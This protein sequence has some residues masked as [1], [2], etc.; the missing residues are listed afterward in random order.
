MKR[1]SVNEQDFL[2]F[3]NQGLNDKEI[4][5]N[6]NISSQTVLKFRKKLN[7]PSK[8]KRKSAGT[9]EIS[10]EQMEL[11]KGTLLG[12]SSLQLV[13]N[14]KTPIFTLYHGPNQRSYA[15]HIAEKLNS[16]GAK[17][18]EYCRLD[19]RTLKEQVSC[20]VI[21]PANASFLELYDNLYKHKKKI[22]TKEFLEGF[23][24]RSLAYLIMDDGYFSKNTIHICTDSFDDDSLNNMIEYFKK[25]F[26]LNFTKEKKTEKHYRLRLK[27]ADFKLF[28]YLVKPY[29]LK[30]LQYKLGD[31]T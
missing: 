23:T 18:K 20:C 10:K 26:D 14:A 16:I 9:I 30:E 17:Y 25:E 22:V 28:K 7:L 29:F 19:K 15:K 8:F 1:I 31:V 2:K 4:G 27:C 3:Y 6:L 5:K 12:D 24:L 21:T 13:Q 11:L